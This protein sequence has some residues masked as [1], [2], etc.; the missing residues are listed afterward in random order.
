MKLLNIL[1]VL[2]CLGVSYPV[3]AT[4]SD[5]G[6]QTTCGL[7]N[8][9]TTSYTIGFSFVDNDHI[10]V[11][12]EN[13]AV[14]PYSRT[15]ISYGTG[16]GKFT[17]TGGDPGTTI[18]MGT[19]PSA[20]EGCVIKR[21]TPRTQLVDY[22]PTQA[23]PAEDHEAQMDKGIMIEQEIDKALSSKV[24]LATGSTAITPTFPDPTSSATLHYSATSQ[25]EAL[26]DSSFL[27]AVGAL[28]LPTLGNAD[29]AL[30]VNGA[31]TSA[32]YAKITTSNI[33]S[34]AIDTAPTAST[35][36]LRDSSGGLSGASIQA[37]RFYGPISGVVTGNVT[38]NLTGNVT[39]NLTG[40]VTGA[41]T[42]NASTA[43]ALAANPTDCG[44]GQFAQSIDAQGN[45]TC[46]SVSSVGGG[47]VRGPV[48]SSDGAPV[49]W[50]DSAGTILRTQAAIPVSA[51]GTS[52]TTLVSAAL[53]VGQGTSAVSS[54]TVPAA[55]HFIGSN[56]TNFVNQKF[57]GYNYWTGFHGP[58]AQWTRT[59]STYGTPT[60]LGTDS[61]STIFSQGM[62]V[63][64]AASNDFG[65]IITPPTTTATFDVDC[66]FLGDNA[67]VSIRSGFQMVDNS[68]I[69]DEAGTR[70][71]AGGCRTPIHMHGILAPGSTSPITVHIQMN[72]SDNTN[73]AETQA[74]QNSAVIW[75]VRQMTP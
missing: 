32:G 45:L 57:P 12:L 28:S 64:A 59:S 39:G 30:V 72:S 21:V 20:T 4:L 69:M 55:Q 63:T 18:V 38:G 35:I 52:S 70:C 49:L 58:N 41:V 74:M 9:V 44:G 34:T 46:A 10:H 62:T 37:T 73:T 61:F 2:L 47:T 68:R 43:T 75:Q 13:R 22:D 1:A 24:G 60:A 65:I 56:G 42:G 14:T 31:G 16:A 6:S 27:A 25:L 66:S 5:Q 11:Y 33:A 54:L 8:G 23:F 19:A 71:L 36:T 48:S 67:G 3:H 53:V 40:N 51:G 7:G 29:E 26:S 15:E 50:A 17:I